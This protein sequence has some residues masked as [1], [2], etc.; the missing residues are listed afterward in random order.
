[1]QERIAYALGFASAD[2]SEFG[3]E[4]SGDRVHPFHE[5]RAPSNNLELGD[6]IRIRYASG[7]SMAGKQI[8]DEIA[9]KL[10]DAQRYTTLE[11]IEHT[12]EGPEIVAV[13]RSL[14]ARDRAMILEA[15]AILY[16]NGRTASA[17]SLM[18]LVDDDEQGR[19]TCANALNA[20]VR[21]SIRGSA[22]IN[23]IVDRCAD[24]NRRRE[25]YYLAALGAE[26]AGQARSARELFVIE[27]TPVISD[28]LTPDQLSHT[29]AILIGLDRMEE[30]IAWTHQLVEQWKYHPSNAMDG[31][32]VDLANRFRSKGKTDIADWVVN[33]MLEVF[34]S[35]PTYFDYDYI[36]NVTEAAKIFVSENRRGDLLE[37]AQRV[38]ASVGENEVVPLLAAASIYELGGLR[39][40]AN[41]KLVAALNVAFKINY[42]INFKIAYK[43]ISIGSSIGSSRL[44]ARGISLAISEIDHRRFE[45]SAAY[46]EYRGKDYAS[47]AMLI[48]NDGRFYLARTLADRAVQP[49]NV[50]EAYAGIL[51]SYLKTNDYPAWSALGLSPPLW[52][53]LKMLEKSYIDSL[54]DDPFFP[55]EH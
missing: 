29:I 40:K 13:P 51:D 11:T 48:A 3:F 9:E 47:L 5:V 18:D 28:R 42:G 50:Y 20:S 36:N 21:L 46:F 12:P 52:P 41:A 45:D 15:A 30:A 31:R 2:M 32:V 53:P 24:T 39:G 54:V 33:D 8:P 19:N 35:P 14:T 22:A 38:E 26:Q 6:M 27:A 10:A 4:D 44:A 34:M 17:T 37:L 25:I 16:L 1:V 23:G 43:L 55:W 49:E 7:L